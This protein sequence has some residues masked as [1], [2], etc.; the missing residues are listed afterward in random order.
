MR[1]ELAGAPIGVVG[2]RRA[3]KIV[4]FLAAEARGAG[5][6]G[7]HARPI[8]ADQTVED[9]TGLSDVIVVL[10]R[11][12]HCFVRTFGQ[13]AAVITRPD[14]Q[15]PATRMW[16]FGIIT[17]AELDFAR[18]IR[19]LWPD[20]AWSN[21]LSAG[22]IERAREVLAERSRRGQRLD[23][24]DCLQL[25][26][27]AQLLIEAPE[28]RRAFGFESHAEA[29]RVVRQLESLRDS[30]A[31]AQDIVAHD[32]PQIIRLASRVAPNAV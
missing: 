21:V 26:D 9:S 7:E 29:K 25:S 4:A 22:R 32:W 17:L 31:H 1:K 27:K 28:Q 30:L 10:T 6:A 2:V 12:D 24:L 20:G 16:L 15:K 8:R 11:H 18:R 19:S 14:I 5:T 3:G 13:P 23:L